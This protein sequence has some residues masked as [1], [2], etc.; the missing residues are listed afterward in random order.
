MIESKVKVTEQDRLSERIL[1]LFTKADT[2]RIN[3]YCEA[4]N[5]DASRGHIIRTLIM[6]KVGQWE[7]RQRSS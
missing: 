1:T 2:D 3:R 6:L 7:K 5:R 4:T